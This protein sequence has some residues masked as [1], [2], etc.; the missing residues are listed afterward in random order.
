MRTN[1]RL[2]C[3]EST[4]IYIKRQLSDISYEISLLKDLLVKYEGS[5][6]D[7]KKYELRNIL[8]KQEKEVHL[9][10]SW[11]CHKALFY[12]GFCRCSRRFCVQQI[13]ALSTLLKTT[14]IPSFFEGAKHL[15][16]VLKHSKM[17]SLNENYK[18]E[19][20]VK[21]G[22]WMNIKEI[23]INNLI[24][25]EVDRLTTKYN[26]D[27]LDCEDLIMITGLGRDNVRNLMRS[28]NFPTTKVGKRQ[29]VSV[30]NFVTWLTLNNNTSEV[31]NG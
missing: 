28:K 26:K 8:V 31:H 17:R 16:W 1:E 5:Y 7:E 20:K 13:D 4:L 6:K 19:I 27:F 12:S 15:N 24:E 22:W 9:L 14:G 2:S 23:N 21:K 3:I 30:L 10:A 11:T 18:G 25:S 29:V